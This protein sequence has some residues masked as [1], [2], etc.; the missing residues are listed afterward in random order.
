ML[1]VFALCILVKNRWYLFYSLAEEQK[2]INKRKVS[3]VFDI[4]VLRERVQR[5]Q[6]KTYILPSS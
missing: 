3:L 4:E 1:V 6:P 5:K 2:N